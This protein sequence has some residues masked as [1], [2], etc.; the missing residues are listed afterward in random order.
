MTAHFAELFDLTMTVDPAGSGTASDDTDTSPYT[1]GTPVSISAVAEEGYVFFNWTAPAGTFD[2]AGSYSTTFTMPGEDVAVTANFL[3]IDYYVS[4]S[5]NPVAAGTTSGD[6]TYHVGD[7]VQ[8][9]ANAS[10]GYTFVNWTDDD[11]SNA[12]VSTNSTYDFIMPAANVNY[13]AN[14]NATP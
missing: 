4:L 3:L 2:D 13:T 12:E 14:F 10:G 1:A 11:N 8:I 5:V 7:A 6:G 9:T